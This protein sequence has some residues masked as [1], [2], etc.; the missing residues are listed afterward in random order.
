MLFRLTQLTWIGP[1]QVMRQLVSY[2]DITGPYSAGDPE[3]ANTTSLNGA[4]SSKKRKQ[5]EHDTHVGGPPPKK[6]QA[7]VE[8]ADYSGEEDENNEMSRD[9][10][11]DEI[12]DDS[13]LIKAWDAANAE[14]EASH[15]SNIIH[16]TLRRFQAYHGPDK[17]RK[18]TPVD[19]SPL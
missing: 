11:Q 1:S 8:V 16:G 18:K 2:D 6:H 9:L 7:N 19:S 5:F 10:T 4:S 17:G 12:W 15:F 3:S 14:Y 13:A